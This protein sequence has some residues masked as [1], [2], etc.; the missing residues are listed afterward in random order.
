MKTLVT[1]MAL[2]LATAFS[3]HAQ[4][5][6]KEQKSVIQKTQV[7][8]QQDLSEQVKN[9]TER[10]T[11]DL[12]LTPEQAE[13]V[14]SENKTLYSEMFYMNSKEENSSDQDRMSSR[15]MDSYDANLQEILDDSQFKKYQ[16]LKADYMK[17]FN[18]VKS[19]N[20]IKMH[21][22]DYD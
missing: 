19:G 21:V 12:E 1:I 16:S 7:Q 8:P 17:G 5:D 13:E 18:K 15:T 3:L 11:K 6:K 20:D 10:M 9:Q 22:I 4:V 14:M 2:F